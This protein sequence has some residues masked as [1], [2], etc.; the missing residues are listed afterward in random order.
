MRPRSESQRLSTQSASRS[1]S[2]SPER[3]PINMTAPQGLG[4]SPPTITPSTNGSFTVSVAD[5]R[6]RNCTSDVLPSIVLGTLRR[7]ITN[8]GRRSPNRWAKANGVRVKR[9][10]CE[11][12]CQHRRSDW[13]HGHEYSCQR[14]QAQGVLCVIAE[15]NGTIRL[16]PKNPEAAAA[17]GPQE[18]AYWID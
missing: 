10:C 18:K 2:L 12:R 5:A 16:L 7:Q 11:I 14:C 1:R 8:W 17:S 9:L 3:P 6:N 15:E 4:S 13:E